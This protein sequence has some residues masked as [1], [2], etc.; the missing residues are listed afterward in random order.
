MP[1]RACCTKGD[2][3]Q[4]E[5]CRFDMT[6]G[7]RS[8]AWLEN[9]FGHRWAGAVTSNALI[10]AG[11]TIID[12]DPIRGGKDVPSLLFNL[13]GPDFVS[14]QVKLMLFLQRLR[15][16]PLRFH[17]LASVSPNGKRSQE[18]AELNFDGVLFFASCGYTEFHSFCLNRLSKK[19]LA[20]GLPRPHHVASPVGI[21]PF[22]V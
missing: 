11:Q 17:D 2:F 12:E 10:K 4:A 5:T 13:E 18:L 6:P 1:C 19:P 9:Y 20:E 14:P 8:P 15:E 3:R 21:F 7:S 22:H 16:P